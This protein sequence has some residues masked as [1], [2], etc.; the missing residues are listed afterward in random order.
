[1]A[2]HIEG[3]G[4]RAWRSAMG[5]LGSPWGERFQQRLFKAV[6]QPRLALPPRVIKPAKRAARARRHVVDLF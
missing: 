1:M 5:L 3:R 6:G 2:I 4:P